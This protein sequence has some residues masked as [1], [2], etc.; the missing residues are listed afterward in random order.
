MR[1]GLWPMGQFGFSV[2]SDP[3]DEPGMLAGLDGSDRRSGGIEITPREDFSSPIVA[4][5]GSPACGKRCVEVTTV[6]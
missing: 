5:L 4:E 3:T 6:K 1:E 2:P